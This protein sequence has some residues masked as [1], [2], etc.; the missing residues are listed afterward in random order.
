MSQTVVFFVCLFCLFCLVVLCTHKCYS[1]YTKEPFTVFDGISGVVTSYKLLFNNLNA[2]IPLVSC[3]NGTGDC[4]RVVY[5]PASSC[6]SESVANISITTTA[7]NI[8]GEGPP[9]DPVFIG[10]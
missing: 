8:L 1:E 7:S 4:E 10:K 5:V 9:S 3:E 6:S 2:N